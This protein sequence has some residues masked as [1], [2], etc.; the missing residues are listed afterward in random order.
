MTDK[1]ALNIR[2]GKHGAELLQRLLSD[3][4]ARSDPAEFV[5][6]LLNAD[7]AEDMGELTGRLVEVTYSPDCTMRVLVT[8]L[9]PREPGESPRPSFW[10]EFPF[11]GEP[12]VHS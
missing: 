8:G 1:T 4:K 6:L 11:Q 7:Q 2:S 10:V 9:E 3:P 12:T 5:R